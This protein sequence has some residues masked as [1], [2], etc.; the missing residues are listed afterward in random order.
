M[1][2]PS[3]YIPCEKTDPAGFGVHISFVRSITM[4]KWS[5]EQ[6]K[7]MRV[8]GNDKFKAFMKDYGSEG[9]YSAGMGMNEKYNSW[10]AAQYREKVRVAR[11]Y[12]AHGPCQ[13]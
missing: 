13:C 10:A 11:P 1:G 8:G 7:K 5:D 12:H 2:N 9:G 4:D 3:R 6:V